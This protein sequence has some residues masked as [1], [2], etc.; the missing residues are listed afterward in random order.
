[1]ERHDVL[2]ANSQWA[3]AIGGTTWRDASVYKLAQRR[4]TTVLYQFNNT[5][6]AVTNNGVYVY[7]G[8]ETFVISVV[9][10]KRVEGECE[11]MS[12]KQNLVAKLTSKHAA[13]LASHTEDTRE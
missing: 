5:V 11:L 12:A 2:L 1:M 9:N 3:A 6:K 8:I 4:Q 10:K 7:V 13:L